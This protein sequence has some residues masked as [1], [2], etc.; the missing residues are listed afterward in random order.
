MQVNLNDIKTQIFLF[1]SPS[2]IPAESP[3]NF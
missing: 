1:V 2:I 3:F